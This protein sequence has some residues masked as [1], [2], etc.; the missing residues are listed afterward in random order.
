MT[1]SEPPDYTHHLTDSAVAHEA[2]PSYVS[3]SLEI[4]PSTSG[5]R[6]LV[7]HPGAS[8]ASYAI[9]LDKSNVSAQA[10]NASNASLLVSVDQFRMRMLQEEVP[11]ITIIDHTDQ[12]LLLTMTPYSTSPGPLQKLEFKASSN[13]GDCVFALTPNVAFN[14]RNTQNLVCSFQLPTTSAKYQW[15]ASIEREKWKSGKKIVLTLY[16]LESE[17]E[18][19]QASKIGSFFKKIVSSSSSYSNRVAVATYETVTP[20]GH[21]KSLRKGTLQ[22][23][24]DQPWKDH[25]EC[26]VFL[27]SVVAAMYGIA[28][29]IDVIQT[30]DMN[31]RLYMSHQKG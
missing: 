22:P 24:S 27:A 5:L 4:S 20:N 14:T 11:A 12:T 1:I 6:L 16:L 17:K 18:S 13:Y 28:Y 9:S 7:V 8:Y 15:E 19:D 10:K 30:M 3:T 2:L 21:E 29:E 31:R 25:N 23:I 26:A